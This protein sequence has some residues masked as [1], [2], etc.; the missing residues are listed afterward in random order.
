MTGTITHGGAKHVKGGWDYTSGMIPGCIEKCWRFTTTDDDDDDDD[1]DD[2]DADADAD[3]GTD[4][5]DDD[6][7]AG[8]DA[9]DDDDDDGGDEDDYD[10]YDKFSDV[11][12]PFESWL[13]TQ[14][15]QSE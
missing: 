4:A 11:L 2:G 14:S 6:A 3:A 1:D 7:D 8:A 9:A 15:I 13:I 12:Q 5:A 10:E